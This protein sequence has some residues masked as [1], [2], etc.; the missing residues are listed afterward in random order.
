MT[1]AVVRVRGTVNVNPDIKKTLQLMNLTKVNHCVLLEEKP[2]EKGMLQVAKDYVTWGEIEKDV[3]TKLI[4]SRGKLD[5][6]KN[7]TDEHLKSSTSFNDVE[8][9]AQAVIENKYRY[10][11]I[12]S[13]KPIFRLNPPKKGYRT[14]KRSFVRKGSLGYRGKEINKLILRMI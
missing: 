7:L 3:L 11:D 13:I 4:T 5:G 10:K 14:I 2:S 8:K 12:P 9:L 1:Y 6:D